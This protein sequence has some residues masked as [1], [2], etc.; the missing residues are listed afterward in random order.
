[1]NRN[2]NIPDEE[3]EIIERYILKQMAQEEY[4]AFD[5]KVSNDTVLQNK[6]ESIKLLLVGIQEVVLEEKLE[7]FH[8]GLSALKNDKSSPAAAIFSIKRWMLA[9]SVIVLVGLGALLLFNKFNKEERIYTEFY[10]PDPGLITVM[11]NSDNYL[12]DHAMIDY[13]TRNYD[14]ALKTWQELLK[15]DPANDTLNYFIGSAYLAENKLDDAISFFK[16]VTKQ[17]H[18]YFLKDANWYIGMAL[19]KQKKTSE[20]IPYIEKADHQNKDAVLMKLKK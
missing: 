16:I 11:G 5:L 14:S 15:R 17:P 13:K 1:L 10:K 12:F 3:F 4:E 8:N 7:E 20:A 19:I 18:S 2:T 6:I 9:A